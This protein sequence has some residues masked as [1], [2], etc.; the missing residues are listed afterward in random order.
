[1]LEAAGCERNDSERWVCRNADFGGATLSACDLS[2]AFFEGAD[3][4][5]VDL[6]GANLTGAVLVFSGLTGADLS[7]ADLTGVSWRR[8]ICPDG[9]NCDNVGG[10]CC[11]N[12]NG[13]VPAAG[14]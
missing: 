7:G 6:A 12:L 8:T 4:S 10:T 9:T 5:G 14:C 1:V 13:A 11:H 3:L 2:L